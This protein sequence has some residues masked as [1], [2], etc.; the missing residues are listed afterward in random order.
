MG[1]CR[2]GS[3]R[4]SELSERV[5]CDRVAPGRGSLPGESTWNNTK[6]ESIDARNER[7]E[8]RSNNHFDG[9]LMQ[10]EILPS[11]KSVCQANLLHTKWLLAPSHRVGHQWVER[12]VRYPVCTGWDSPIAV[13]S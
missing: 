12:L 13:T 7:A 9:D 4:A 1:G 2:N 10:S 6:A 11:L 8:R 5:V 3:A